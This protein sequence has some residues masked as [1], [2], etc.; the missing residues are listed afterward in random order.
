MSHAADNAFSHLVVIGSSAGGVEALSELVSTQAEAELLALKDE[1]GAD[2]SAMSRLHELSTQLLSA[3]ELRPL[4]EEILDA[5][6]KLQSADFGNIQ[7]YDRETGKLDIVVHRGFTQEFLDYFS[8]TDE[9]AACGRA[10]KQ[11][12]RVIIE[13]VEKDAQYEAHRKIAAS[14]GYRAVQSTPL[15]DREGKPLGMLSTHFR[16]PHRPS[17]RE[18]RMTDLFA[19]QAAEMIGSKLVEERLRRSEERLR[20]AMEIETVG[21]IFFNADG[22]ITDAN[23]AFLRM[24]GY[25]RED[26]AGEPLRWDEMTPP[27]WMPRSLKAL[28]ELQKTGRTTPYEKEYIRK[29]GS[30]WWGLFAA[31]RLS[32][33]ESVEFI[34]DIT[35]RQ[36]AEVERDRLLTRELRARAQAEERRRLSRELHDRVAHDMALVHQS[37]ELY[38]ALKTSDSE[39]ASAK[40]ELA[41]AKARVALDSTRNLSMELRQPEVRRGLEAAFADLLRD[42]VP[43]KMSFEL[44]VKGDEALRTLDARNQLFLILREAIRNAVT[45]SGCRRISVKLTIAPDKIVGSVEDDGQGFE[46]AHAT[47]GQ[48]L[49]LMEE[50]AALLGGTIEVSSVPGEGTKV[51]VTAP[52]GGGDG[53]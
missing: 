14:A 18:L 4:L 8:D 9:N 11:G 10:L 1:L 24:S 41:K 53:G 42:I 7:L 6:I 3:S 34:I 26:L 19:R 5:S 27:E 13:D 35:E 20:R 37:L 36:Q 30:R 43:P 33:D 44:S 22:N 45:Y 50:R 2:L 17:E 21:V 46:A 47:D 29:D 49:R 52:S 32:E 28:E 48:G 25:S 38:E 39:R 31:T 51:R 15:F 23:D 40:L 12:K 16:K